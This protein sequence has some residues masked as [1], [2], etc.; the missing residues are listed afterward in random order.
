MLTQVRIA[1]FAVAF[2]AVVTNTHAQ[3]SSGPG[4]LNRSDS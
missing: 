2:I 1:G 3:A 4:F